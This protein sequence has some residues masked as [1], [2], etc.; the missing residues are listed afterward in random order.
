MKT[1]IRTKRKELKLTQQQLADAC[2]INR[3][4]LNRIEHGVYNPGIET[5]AKLAA[6]LGCTI[7][8]LVKETA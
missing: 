8:E 6:A 4:T 7:D 5:A 1:N 3:V 2:G